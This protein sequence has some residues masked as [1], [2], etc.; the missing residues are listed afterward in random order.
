MSKIANDCLTQSGTGC[1]I[2]VP[3]WQQWASRVNRILMPVCM[4]E[5][6]F[7]CMNLGIDCMCSQCYV[8]CSRWY[9]REGRL[10]SN[11]RSNSPTESLAG[12]L[13]TCTVTSGLSFVHTHITHCIDSQHCGNI[14]VTL[15]PCLLWITTTWHVFQAGQTPGFSRAKLLRKGCVTMLH[16]VEHNI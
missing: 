4:H 12:L 2:V 16:L 10:E 15:G 13:S 5:C 6:L 7:V 1:F 9:S 3:I 8:S 11:H 14:A